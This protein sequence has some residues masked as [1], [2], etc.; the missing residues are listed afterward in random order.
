MKT[1]TDPAT[2][3]TLS[4][5]AARLIDAERGV[6]AVR[7]AV[8]HDSRPTYARAI[9]PPS[10]YWTAVTFSERGR[11]MAVTGASGR[12]ST[13]EACARAVEVSA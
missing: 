11:L 12:Y 3:A 8:R 1:I 6:Y 7:R 2:L 4:A 10:D 13:A 9:L 5:D